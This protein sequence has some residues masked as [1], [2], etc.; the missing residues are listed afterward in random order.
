MGWYIFKLKHVKLIAVMS[1][2]F[3]AR[4]ALSCTV[5]G[6]GQGESQDAFILTTAFMTLV[7]LIMIGSVV[8]FIYR[9]AKRI[10]REHSNS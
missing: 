10:Q 9:R 5:C 7:P 1:L 6:F 3:C 4:Q 8:F 2:V